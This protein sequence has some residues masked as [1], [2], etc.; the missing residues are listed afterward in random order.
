MLHLGAECAVP[1]RHIL[2][3][4]DLHTA[5]SPDTRALLH[6]ARAIGAV[7]TVPEGAPRSAVITVNEAGTQHIYLSPISSATLRERNLC[8]WR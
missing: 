1:H 5:D 4:L 7:T 8:A 3:I 6:R 2:A